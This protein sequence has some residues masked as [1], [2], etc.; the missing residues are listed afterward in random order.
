M[1]L[2]PVTASQEIFARYCNY[3]QTTFGLNDDDLNRQI[4]QALQEPGRFARGPIL[5]VTPP[6]KLGCTILDLINGGVLTSHLHNLR[7]QSLPLDRPLYLHQEEAISRICKDAR[8]AVVA[9]GTGSGKTECFMIPILHH[10]FA[11]LGSGTLTPGVRA[12]L[13][14]PMNALAND[15]M[16]RLRQVLANHPQITF[17]IY[18]GE[19]KE[20]DSD[21]YAKYRRMFEKDPLPNELI[22][23]RQMKETPPHILLTNYA[24][25]EYLMLRPEDHVFFQGPHAG[26]WKFIVLDEAHTYAGAK[27]IEMSMLLARLKNAIGARPGE[28]RCILTSASLGR[29]REDAEAVARFASALFQEEFAES[30][31]ITAARVEHGGNLD[32]PW[33]RPSPSLYRELLGWLN[34]AA[35]DISQLKDILQDAGI[36]A[37][38]AQE[39]LATAFHNEN[40]ALYQLLKGDLGVREIMR[41]VEQGPVDVV[42]LAYDLFGSTPEA[43]ENMTALVD[44]CNRAR[45]RSEDNPLLPARYHFFVKALEGAFVALADQPKVYLERMNKVSIQGQMYRT[46]ELGACSR[47]RG[48]YLIG[49]VR[50]AESGFH[51]L[52]PVRNRYDPESVSGMAYFALSGREPEGSENEDDVLEGLGLDAPRF[53]RYRLCVHC[54]GIG[55]ENGDAV[56]SCST[57]KTVAVTKVVA[58]GREVHKCGL[59]GAV[60]PAA[61]VVR[62]FF[63]SEDA[64]AAVLATSLFQQLPGW[65]IEE[66][67][68]EAGEYNLFQLADDAA[69]SLEEKRV[70]QLL[71]FSDSR[72]NAAYFAP[73]LS[74]TY[75]DLVAKNFLVQTL[76]AHRDECLAH[77]WSLADFSRRI[78]R[79]LQSTELGEESYETMSQEVW[80]W[81]MR[82]FAVDT[83]LSS[84]ENMGLLAFVP[85]FERVPRSEVLF[86]LKFVRD[87]GFSQEE[88]EILFIF[89]L[90]Q[91]RLNRA[92]EYPEA[93]SPIDEFFAPQNQQ[94]GFWRQK[95]PGLDRQPKGY[96]LKGW[97]PAD[98]SF[99]NTRLDY[100]MRLLAVGGVQAS[101]EDG[102]E[103]LRLLFEAITD[104]RSPLAKYVKTEEARGAGR[105]YKLDPGL[106][107]VLPGR[108]RGAVE[109][110]R[111]DACHK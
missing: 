103:L 35:K 24:M 46:F 61:S 21:A 42:D 104:P 15:Q 44:L 69:V 52:E 58:K 83:G 49:E 98:G 31:V 59:C 32:A 18:T 41:S 37:H 53:D 62:R 92:V 9:T 78:V 72:Q 20:R 40:L 63:L 7:A 66:S 93:V 109:Y 23:R 85:D 19:T 94:G 76:E 1:S 80:R 5:E 110:Y 79:R 34:D 54:G 71:V 3:I 38:K 65:V 27:G 26:R 55:L 105:I 4:A 13:L 74:S 84:L 107:K 45:L 99:S 22:S 29:G 56:C 77:R 89:L 33:G 95:P 39:F 88:A 101:P 6:F 100:L 2:N 25:L 50:E 70:K 86:N 17:G 96:S 16:K 111:C 28:L 102:R 30:D 47:C 64:V 68:H 106:Y 14:Y 48:L 51:Y 87:A 10:L 90:D 8:N 82:E 108:D 11:E 57:P 12:L 73:Y 91:F 81:I 43:V 60:S 97:L 75:R 67:K 36:P